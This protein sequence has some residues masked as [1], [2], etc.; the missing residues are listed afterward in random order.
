MP[1][2]PTLVR[3]SLIS[4]E[5]SSCGT[6]TGDLEFDDTDGP[7]YTS[8]SGDFS[9]ARIWREPL[10]NDVYTWRMTLQYTDTGACQGLWT[11]Q[12]TE[13]DDDPV[14]EYQGWDGD[15]CTGSVIDIS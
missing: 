3:V 1:I 5:G 11:L 10:G 14:G 2:Y 9:F 7:E 4:C 13:S 6:I 15:T 12:R 8:T